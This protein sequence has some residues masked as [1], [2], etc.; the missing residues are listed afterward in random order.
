MPTGSYFQPLSNVAYVIVGKLVDYKQLQTKTVI[1]E[2]DVYKHDN[3][4]TIV[5]GWGRSTSRPVVLQ[6]HGSWV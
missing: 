2:Q 4:S 6:L 3:M 5:S 1:D